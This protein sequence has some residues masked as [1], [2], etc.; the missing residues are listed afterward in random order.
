MKKIV[1]V[2]L[3][4]AAVVGSAA[5]MDWKSYPESVEKGKFLV[6]AGIGL[7]DSLLGYEFELP[8]KSI[9]PIRASVDYALFAPFTVGAEAGFFFYKDEWSGLTMKVTDSGTG[10]A[11]AGRFGYHPDFGVK[12]LDVYANVGLGLYILS[13]KTE[14]KYTDESLKS[15][16]AND[17][18]FAFILTVGARYF[19]TENIGVFADVGVGPLSVFTGG[20][21]LKF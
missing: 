18:E 7:G 12:N 17:S 14:T 11:F 13:W 1:L 3:M 8:D 2:L 19:F 15:N 16:D 20:V 9:P 10:L 6:N 5:A 21:A 4:I